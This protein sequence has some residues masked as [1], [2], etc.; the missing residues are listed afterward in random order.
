VLTT[1]TMTPLRWMGSATTFALIT[2]LQLLSPSLCLATEPAEAQIETLP[3]EIMVERTLPAVVQVRVQT[4]DGMGFGSGFI[5]KSSGVVV[6]NLHVVRDASAVAIKLASNEVFD[7]VRVVGFDEKRDLVLLKFA[8]FNLPTI[9]LGNSDEVK[10]GEGVVAIGHP[11]GFENT[12][13]QGIVSSIRVLNSGVK[14]IQTDVAASPG[15]SG[16][17]LLNKRGQVVGVVSF[18]RGALEKRLIFAY[19]INYVQGLLALESQMTLAELSSRLAGKPDLFASTSEGG[20]G[21]RWKSLRTGTLKT[22]RVEGEFIYGDQSNPDGSSLTYELRKQAD[23]TYA[24]HVRQFSSCW[25]V[26]RKFVPWQGFVGTRVEKSFVLEHHIAFTKVGP[27]RIEGKLGV[28]EMSPEAGA[29]REWCES[30]G[31]S[32]T[33]VWREFTWVRA[34]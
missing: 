22:L 25:Y 31:K 32:V 12:V 20:L 2:A 28:P 5:V 7:E 33:P 4:R 17:P 6:T 14:V 1:L 24:G 21:G 23:G 8:G 11:S 10:P 26:N 13:T 27:S 34:E 15:N 30:G 3:T 18:W 29:L 9:P 16:G 19:P